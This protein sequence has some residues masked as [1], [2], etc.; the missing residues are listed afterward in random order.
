MLDLDF[1]FREFKP[2]NQCFTR[3][4]PD[5]GVDPNDGTPDGGGNPGTPTGGSSIASA[6]LPATENGGVIGSTYLLFVPVQDIRTGLCYIGT[7]DVTSFDDSGDGGSYSYRAEDIVK[8]KT[9]T[10]NK[11]ILIY[12]DLGSAKLTVTL[13]VTND[14][15]QVKTASVD[16]QI[17]NAIP[18]GALITKLVY[19]QLT[20]YR[21]QLTLSRKA[22]DGPVCITS[23]TMSGEIED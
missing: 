7:Y 23:A 11:V 16:V 12:R 13:A 18:T 21:P 22:G 14:N 17:G 8:H 5:F 4:L 2:R 6:G 20:G 9:P 15:A 3:P 10:V 19:L 1:K